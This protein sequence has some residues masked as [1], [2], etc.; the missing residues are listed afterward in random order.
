MMSSPAL[1]PWSAS[2]CRS[3]CYL[4]STGIMSN[5]NSP[6]AAQLPLFIHS[7]WKTMYF[8]LLGICG[9]TSS[10]AVLFCSIPASLGWFLLALQQTH[11]SW[12]L[13]I[14]CGARCLEL[15][16]GFGLRLSAP[17]RVGGLFHTSHIWHSCSYI[18][19]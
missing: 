14:L 1:S 2:R 4:C 9:N 5:P 10:C 7:I 15:G 17:S 13:H 11:C 3:L 19:T 12:L 16:T 8:L 6:S 18:P